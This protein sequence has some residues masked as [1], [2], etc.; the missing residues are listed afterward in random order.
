MLY[1]NN[2][3]YDKILVHEK[4][5]KLFIKRLPYRLN[6]RLFEKGIYFMKIEL[7]LLYKLT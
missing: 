6:K 5:S 4:I 1:I 7:N 3:R 2:N